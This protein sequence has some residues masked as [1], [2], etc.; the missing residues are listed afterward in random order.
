MERS[1]N[2]LIGLNIFNDHKRVPASPYDR[3]DSLLYKQYCHKSGSFYKKDLFLEDLSKMKVGEL[4]RA[5]L[6]EE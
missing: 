2:V 5:A 4:S 3:L 1:T 6:T